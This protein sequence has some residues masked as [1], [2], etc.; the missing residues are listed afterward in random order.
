MPAG[1][2]L[3]GRSS[4]K[5]FRE[6]VCERYDV[7]LDAYE[8]TVFWRCVFR[9]AIVSALPVRLLNRDYFDDDFDL[10]HDVGFC[11]SAAEA[12]AEIN[13][14]R[15]ARAMRGF[16]RRFLHVRVSGRRLANLAGRLLP[17]R[18]EH[19]VPEREWHCEILAGMPLFFDM[20]SVADGDHPSRFGGT[21]PNHSQRKD[22]AAAP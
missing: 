6:A 20:N 17:R 16:G 21:S 8:K 4:V 18:S 11:T 14:H 15:R 7:S 2:K 13:K 9:W 12:C 10:I 5:T 19:V 1:L 3:R 22:A